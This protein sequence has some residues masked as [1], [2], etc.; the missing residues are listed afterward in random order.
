LRYGEDEMIDW[1]LV[2]SKKA[3]VVP[4][5]VSDKE[6]STTLANKA[7]VEARPEVK[8]QPVKVDEFDDDELDEAL[9][10]TETKGE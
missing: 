7:P 8:V 3:P 10:A 2:P 5:C 4:K 9:V 6:N 1:S